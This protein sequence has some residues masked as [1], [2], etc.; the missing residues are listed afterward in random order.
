MLTT[1]DMVGRRVR[2]MLVRT[3]SPLSNVQYSITLEDEN[4]CTATDEIL[5]DVFINRNLYVPNV[6]SPNGDQVN[7]YF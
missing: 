1:S 4:G 3:I 5:V 2:W 6:F 7:D